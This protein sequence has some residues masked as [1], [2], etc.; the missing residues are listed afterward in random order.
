M[1][2]MLKPSL[3][4]AALT[5]A[6]SARDDACQTAGRGY[7]EARA[8]VAVALR[9]YDQCVAASLGRYDCSGEFGEL[10]LEQDRFE[11]AVEGY[12]GECQQR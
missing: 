9:A 5:I 2:A 7:D 1:L 3:M 11:R 12:R 4:I 8:A 10:E 6:F